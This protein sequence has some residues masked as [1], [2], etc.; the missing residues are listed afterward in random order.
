MMCLLEWKGFMANNEFTIMAGC[1]HD[2]L[3][4]M[5]RHSWMDAVPLHHATANWRFNDSLTIW[6][7][8]IQKVSNIWW[9]FMHWNWRNHM[10]WNGCIFPKKLVS[11]GYQQKQLINLPTKPV[12]P[13]TIVGT[14]WVSLRTPGQELVVDTQMTDIMSQSCH[15]KPK[16]CHL[17]WG[18]ATGGRCFFSE[19][20]YSQMVGMLV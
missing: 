14:A 5:I 12:K 9:M 17:F 10:K 8:V 15:Q 2:A 19:Y 3:A 16:D 6:I 13:P 11:Q 1:K 4:S 20:I 7:S 18:E